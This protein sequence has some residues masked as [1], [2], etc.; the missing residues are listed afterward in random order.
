MS[1]APNGRGDDEVKVEDAE[2]V[3]EGTNL[4]YFFKGHD[5]FEGTQQTGR[6]GPDLAT[7]KNETRIV[8]ERM[9]FFYFKHDTGT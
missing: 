8:S 6:H 1:C 7:S 3:D 9:K 5:F 4:T 2:L